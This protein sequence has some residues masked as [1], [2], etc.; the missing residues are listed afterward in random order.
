MKILIEYIIVFIS[1]LIVMK[2]INKKTITYELLYLKKKYKIDVKNI[3]EKKLLNTISIVNSFIIT[4]IY[5]ILFYL[6][7]NWILGII[8]GVILI[9][10]LIIICYGLLGRY[11]SK[12]RRK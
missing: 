10:L 5:I 3:N 11:Y 7:K 9:T 4:T 6:V 8:I 2:I 12:E 1:V